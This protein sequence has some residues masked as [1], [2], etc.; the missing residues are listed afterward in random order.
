MMNLVLVLD[1]IRSAHNVGSLLRTADGLGLKQIFACGLTPHPRQ[2]ND[3][4]LPHVI[5]GA[6]RKLAKTALGAELELEILYAPKTVE[7]LQ[8]LKQRGYTVV[9]LEQI[10][11]AVDIAHWNLTSQNLALV[12]GHETKGLS[13]GVVDALDE[14][15]MIPMRGGKESFNVAVAG[16]IAMYSLLNRR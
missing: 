10:K 14:A 5:D 9:G 11:D 13:R 2:P 3:P 7:L 16:A 15:V 4:R 6:Q 8:E 1:N 12:V